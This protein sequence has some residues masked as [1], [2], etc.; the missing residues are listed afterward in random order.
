MGA[1]FAGQ[2]NSGINAAWVLCYLATSPHWLAEVRKEVEAVAEKYHPGSSAPLADRLTGLP[3]EA[4]ETE[5]PIVDL[6]LRDSIRLQVQGTGMRRNISGHSVSIGDEA[7]P[8][9]AFLLYHFANHHLDPAVYADPLAWD[10]ARYMPGRAEDKKAPY[11][12]IGWG[13]GRHPCLGM[14]F[15]KLEQNIIAA[16]FVAL[17]DFE[18]LD[19]N[20]QVLAAPPPVNYNNW[21]AAGPEKKVHLRFKVR[22]GAM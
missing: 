8:P 9:D 18:L 16:F 11:A 6:C 5:F 21:T 22:E 17:F 12:F 19:H 10:P 20:L 13:A 2:I 4:W 14:R 7:V 3:L 15:A 1:V